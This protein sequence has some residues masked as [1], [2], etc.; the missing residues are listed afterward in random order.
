LKSYIYKTVPTLLRDISI[1]IVGSALYAFGFAAF[2]EPLSISPGGITGIA[3][4]LSYLSGIPAGALLFLLNLPL[5]IIGFIKLGG[6]MMIKTFI[7]IFCSSIFIDVF[8]A[9]LPLFTTDKIIASLSS[10][11]AI[12]FG[13]SIIFLFGG[14]SGGTDIAA[15]LIKR[16][17]PFLSIG[18]LILILDGAVITLSALVYA[19]IEAALYS[20]LTILVS[21]NLID[22]MLSSTGG[23]VAIIITSN[24]ETLKKEIIENMGRG[25]SIIKAFG[26][27]SGE[28]KTVLICALSRR[29]TMDFKRMIKILEPKAFAIITDAE[30]IMGEGFS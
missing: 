18:R 30:E 7:S 27:Y 2:L 3:A 21:S 17:K 22:K 26:G 9:I 12:G 28:E 11:V 24:S 15:K 13:L 5:I 23:K 20:V 16:K 1:M 19:N 4:V 10:G 14:T 6:N 29:Q 8:S 25:V